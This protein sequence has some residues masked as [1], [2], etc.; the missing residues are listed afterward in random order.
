VPF[1]PSSATFAFLQLTI[2][3]PSDLDQQRLA[4]DDL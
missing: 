1:L 3:H 2:A 4:Q